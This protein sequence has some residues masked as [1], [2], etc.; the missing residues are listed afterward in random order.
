MGMLAQELEALLQS[1]WMRPHFP[2]VRQSRSWKCEQIMADS[3]IGL[4]HDRNPVIGQLIIIIAE[5]TSDG[6]FNGKQAKSSAFV[7][8]VIKNIVEGRL[9]DK[10]GI[11]E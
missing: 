4:R 11:S 5:R 9:L 6:I 2:D 10:M 1:H 8:Y 7:L 3:Q